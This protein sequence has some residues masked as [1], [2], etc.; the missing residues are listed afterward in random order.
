M[1]QERLLAEIA[2]VS[3][4]AEP[5]RR[6]LYLYVCA[7][8]GEVTRDQAA[9]AVDTSRSMA[10][11]HLDRLVE[12]GLLEASFRRLTGRSG[13]GAG[14]PAK[15]YR[16]SQRQLAVSLPPRS[17]ELAAR[18]L[19]DA[20]D[21]SPSPKL[22]A[23]LVDSARALGERIGEDAAV[24]VS[25]AA[26]KGEPLASLDDALVATGFEPERTAADIRFRNCPFHA[27]TTEHR[28]LVCGMNLALV[29]GMVSGAGVTEAKP[30]L[31]P[32]PGRCCVCIDL[33][34]AR[35]RRATSSPA[36]PRRRQPHRAAATARRTR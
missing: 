17:Y 12:Q 35:E 36:K 29:E 6:A 15:L 19:A 14:R 16:R 20:V 24:H 2:G 13:P 28:D 8:D 25:T 10:G 9:A 11:F 34:R 31:D 33:P 32:R 27:L 4:L 21:A 5:V 7:Q 30:R 23:T 18:I 3:A 22:R 1:E 26:E